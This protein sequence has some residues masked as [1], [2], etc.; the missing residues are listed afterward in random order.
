MVATVE[1]DLF[2]LDDDGALRGRERVPPGDVIQTVLH[3]ERNFGTSGL[4]VQVGEVGPRAWA[5][6]VTVR[7]GT[8]V[9]GLDPSA[10][11]SSR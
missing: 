1:G 6:A 7:W 4:S 8:F 10:L 3:G 5:A 9:Y 2:V 11:S